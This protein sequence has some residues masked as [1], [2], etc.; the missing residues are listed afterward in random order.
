MG[1]R[2]DNYRM[3]GSSEPDPVR[4]RWAQF[5]SAEQRHAPGEVEGNLLVTEVTGPTAPG[6]HSPSPP[7]IVVT[8]PADPPTGTKKPKNS[9]RWLGS[10]PI[11]MTKL[12]VTNT[13]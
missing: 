2:A 11:G 6:T 10:G 12:R 9:G 3:A 5:P 7:G 1:L 8:Y 13:W 4:C